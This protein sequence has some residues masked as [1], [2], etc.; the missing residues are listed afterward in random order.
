[1]VGLVAH[2]LAWAESVGGWEK[3]V[4]ELQ[5]TSAASFASGV[6]F[7]AGLLILPYAIPLISRQHLKGILSAWVIFF[8]IVLLSGIS[9]RLWLSGEAASTHG[10]AVVVTPIMYQLPLALLVVLVAYAAR[11]EGG[12]P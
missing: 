6:P 2:S 10:W 12:A 3:A 4:S 9:I 11:R 1:M 7:M 8:G 5:K